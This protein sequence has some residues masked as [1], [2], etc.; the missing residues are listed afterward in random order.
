MTLLPPDHPDYIERPFGADPSLMPHLYA[1][2]S[3][4][5]PRSQKLAHRKDGLPAQA[6]VLYQS[7]RFPWIMSIHRFPILNAYP[8]QWD[9]ARFEVPPGSPPGRYI[10][11][12][13]W[14]GYRD[15]VDIDV[16]PDSTPVPN[17]PRAIYGYRPE[18]MGAY[19]GADAQGYVKTD[20]CQYPAPYNL[21][22]HIRKLPHVPQATTTDQ[23]ETGGGVIKK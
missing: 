8:T 17:T 15:C 9:I 1:Y 5:L 22:R 16:L 23:H 3:D 21:Q 13:A 4:Q 20:H 14:R 2:A 6:R 19:G 7:E 11:Y 18:G 10:L 12:Y